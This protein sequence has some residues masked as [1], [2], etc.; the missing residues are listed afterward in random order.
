M[1][2]QL[3]HPASSDYFLMEWGSNFNFPH[4][5]HQ[6]F[7]FIVS[8]EGKMTVIIGAAEYEIE[9]GEAVLIFPNQVHALASLSN[10]HMLCIFSPKLVAAY[11]AK[12]TT[13][14]PLNN[15]FTPPNSLVEAFKSFDENTSFLSQKGYLY[16]LCDTFDVNARYVD[17][18]QDNKNLLEKILEFIETNYKEDCSLKELAASI[19]Y[20]YVYLSRYF[21]KVVGMSFNSYVNMYRLNN[22]CYLLNNS[23][24]SILN[25]AMES[26]Y[27]SIRSFNRNFKNYFG[28]SPNEY[29]NSSFQTPAKK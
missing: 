25:S 12:N 17:G 3:S 21:K 16:L 24:D 5:M 6:C 19:G 7:E 26:G 18:N 27:K 13:R 14:L 22:A 2:Y 1:F 15:K 4:H 20:S 10:K 8:L 28:V 29:L 9:E 23:D 11:Y